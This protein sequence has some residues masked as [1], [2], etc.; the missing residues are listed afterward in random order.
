MKHLTIIRHAK[1]S[2]ENP[3]LDD[4][5]RPLNT[6]GKQAIV[7]I[8]DYLKNKKIEPDLIIT[9]PATRALQTAIGIGTVLKYKTEDLKIEQAI[10]FGNTT[11]VI[12]VI[13]NTDNRLK[14]VFIF[15]HEPVLSSVIITLSGENPDKFPTGAVCRIRFDATNWKDI[16]LKKGICEFFV[17]PK[18]LSEK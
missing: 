16:T 13:E 11:S 7:L 12:R 5:V 3:E 2:W 1:S 10:Y 14:D 8:G 15:G 4:M 17:N 9:S 18:L 6:R